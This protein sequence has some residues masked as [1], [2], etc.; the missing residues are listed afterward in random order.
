VHQSTNSDL[1]ISENLI[2]CLEFLLKYKL[3]EEAK[4]IEIGIK[5]IESK[6]KSKV[7]NDFYQVDIIWLD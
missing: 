5:G 4:T 1:I 2:R 7:T 3:K 6:S